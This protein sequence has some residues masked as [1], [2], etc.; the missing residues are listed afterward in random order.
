MNISEIA[1]GENLLVWWRSKD[2]RKPLNKKDQVIS[3]R[4]PQKDFF[5]LK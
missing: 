1:F 3:Y 2:N 4:K 5:N